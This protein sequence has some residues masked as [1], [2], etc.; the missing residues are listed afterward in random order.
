[1]HAAVA[2]TNAVAY[3]DLQGVTITNTFSNIAIG[4]AKVVCGSGYIYV[5]PSYEGNIISINIGS[6]QAT[7]KN[8]FDYVSGGTYDF[9]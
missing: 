1:M 2:F 8:S 7:T 5:F 9:A 3:V 4:T 6:G